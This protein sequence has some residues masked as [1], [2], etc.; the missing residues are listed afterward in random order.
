MKLTFIGFGILSTICISAVCNNSV[1]AQVTPDGSLGT[2]VNGSSNYHITEGT[3]V[4]NNLFH[5]FSQFSISTGSS[6]S[7]DNATDI[8]NIFS[9]VSG[10]NIS[11]IDG[12]ISAKGS[13]NLFLLNPSGMI[14]GPNASLNIGGSFVGTTANSI[15]FADGI[16]FSAID[17][18]T[19]PLLTMSIPVGLQLG[20]NAGAI[21]AQGIPA[22]N[23]FFRPLQTFK[24]Q[25]VALVGSEIDINS[26]SFSNPDGRFELWALRNG[27]V[28]LSNQAKLQLTSPISAD[29]GTVTLSQSSLLDTTG[30]NGG[31]INIHGRGL[32]LKDGS[33]ISSGTGKFGQGEGINVKTT[34]FVDLL[35]LS[36]PENYDLPG[37]STSPLESG[38]K[39]GDI[40]IK[41][42][43]L[44]IAN[45]AW[46]QSL[47][48]ILAL[49]PLT[50]TFTFKTINDASTGNI[51]ILAKDVEVNGYNPFVNADFG[52]ALFR[53]SAITT[54]VNG[55]NR[56]NSGNI[57]IEADRV[58]LLNGG[59]IST[60]LVSFGFITTGKSGDISI[61]SA[62]SLE[63]S[64]VTPSGLNGAV[65]SSI[66]PFAEGQGGS[67][68]INT[69]HLALSKG[70]TISS[71]L[72]GSGK[73][74]NIA[75][76]ANNVEVSDPIIDSISLTVSGINVAVAKNAIGQSGNIQLTADSLR[77]FNGG[78]I[79][80]SSQGQGNAGSVNLQV[81]NL[82]VQ[83]TSQNL[84]NGSYLNS[85]IAAAS[86]NSF[87]AGSVNITSDAVR[88]RD[89]AEIT[90]S[91]T[92]SGDAGNLNINANQIFLDNEASLRSEVHGGGQGNIYLN[93][94]NVLLLRHGSNIITNAF[95]NSTGGNI[96]INA[97]SIVAVPTENSDISANAVLGSGGNI[98]ITTQSIFGLQFQNQ[99]TPN[100]D[101]TASSQ[102]GLSGTVQVNTVGVDPNSG[103]VELP[104]NITDPSQQIATGCSANTGS[105][106]VATGRG[107]VPE[108]P[109]QELRSD[110][111]W[112]DTRDISVFH[113]TQ[114]AQAQIHTTSQVLVQATGW[115]RN[116]N[117][118]IELVANQSPTQVQTTLTCAAIPQN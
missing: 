58:R 103:L 37:L 84:I 22:N 93:A 46:L 83:G 16:E 79:T 40:T 61:K 97:G 23:I 86:D 102:F 66:Q 98:Q 87:A 42:E 104:T 43:R 33:T 20:A 50:A 56:N 91:N 71:A 85:A 117:G 18:T 17:T 5:S 74:G 114:P 76:Q 108:N 15:K 25:T 51:N 54:L 65:I 34:E 26:A 28:G 113:T 107:G 60:D 48:N 105:S 75:I 55:G 82:D 94:N 62:E 3:R 92:G 11:H 13:A 118:K 90:V 110:R 69:G 112:S 39:A 7:F 81:K 2:V 116:A 14:F 31:A 80:S 27:E 52:I 106:F 70:G 78:Q 109:T 35:G 41:T 53:P 24:A 36:S 68:S 47:C 99:L 73:A 44:R 38:A 96:N 111:A 95:G 115:R 77:V 101:I 4:G 88:V 9:R 72:S 12:L 100:S 21:K 32:T 30:L 29:W 1:Y 64:G 45:G 8:Q 63:I 49:D 59:R 19:K 89:N 10:S 57:T 6:A 67:I